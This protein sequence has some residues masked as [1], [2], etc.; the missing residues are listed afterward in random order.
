MVTE[1]VSAEE[2]DCILP[3][4]TLHREPQLW[5]QVGLISKCCV[6][7]FSREK[8]VPHVLTLNTPLAD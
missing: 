8:A 6:S 5:T 3:C 1:E 4:I 7:P 2:R